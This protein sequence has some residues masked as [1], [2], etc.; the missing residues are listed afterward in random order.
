MSPLT[1]PYVYWEDILGGQASETV[2][3]DECSSRTPLRWADLS[4]VKALK[5]KLE[6]N[7]TH[8]TVCCVFFCP[9][10]KGNWFDPNVQ[11]LH[12][13]LSSHQT[14]AKVHQSLRKKKDTDQKVQRKDV[15]P[16]KVQIREALGK[17]TNFIKFTN[18]II[19]PSVW[20]KSNKETGS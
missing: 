16:L 9:N 6:K 10:I 14:R 11:T 5:N 1:L 2:S 15:F 20:T 12:T 8:Y 19:N 7:N 17:I 18:S 4:S 3:L 13:T